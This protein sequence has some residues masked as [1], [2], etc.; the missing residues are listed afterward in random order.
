M[1][2][3]KEFALRALRA[4]ARRRTALEYDRLHLVVAAWEVADEDVTVSEIAE[5]SGIAR[6]TVYNDLRRAG[7]TYARPVPPKSTGPRVVE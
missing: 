4:W 7:I 5:A 3:S 2:T 1:T 6:G